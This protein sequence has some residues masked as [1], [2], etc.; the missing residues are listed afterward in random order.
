MKTTETAQSNHTTMRGAAAIAHILQ[1]EGVDL[2]TCFPHNEMID[3]VAD[4]GTQPIMCRTERIAIHIAD[5]YSRLS[6]GKKTPVVFVQDGPGIENAFGGVAQA[7]GD[8]TPMLLM[9]GGYDRDRQ[10]IGPNFQATYNFR[11]ITKWVAEVN[12]SARI[13]Q[14]MHYAFSQLRNGPQ[15]PVMLEVPTDVMEEPIANETVAGYQSPPSTQAS[16]DPQDVDEVVEALLAAKHPVIVAG[17]GIFYA[18]ACPAL[19]QFAELTQIPVMTT[20]NGK[21]AFPENH[22]LALGTGGASRTKMV[23]HFLD[24][25]DFVLGIGTSF[26][27]SPYIT[28]IPDGKIIAQIT[29]NSQD[30]GKDYVISYGVLGDAKLVLEQM[31]AKAQETLGKTG[32]QGKTAIANEVATVKAEF[33]AEWL[34]RLTNDDNP[35]SPY[36]VIWEVMQTFDR[37]RTT[38]TH[39]AGSP[40]DQVTATY[41]AIVPHGYIGWGKTTHLGTSL[42]LAMGA[43]LA[44]PDWYAVNIM[45]DG[46]FGMVGIDFET[47]VRYQIPICT[48]ILNNGVLG[49]YDGYLPISTEKF[50]TRN[51]T[52]DYAGVAQ[53]LGGY[54]ERVEQ[55]ADLKLALQRAIREMDAGRPVLLDVITREESI[56]AKY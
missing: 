8:N 50:G 55:V 30:I 31:I 44:K 33:M 29:H 14:M 15:G 16:G 35:I 4:L 17:Q 52:G 38:V 51:L 48:I 40:R 11:N 21:S 7:Y 49:G 3:T 53:S 2:V 25:A 36:R 6:D 24:K 42:G 32:R 47:A 23:R 46:A 41:E 9:P 37:T 12:Q 54:T 1:K 34:P 28:P 5:G 39:E 22:P 18:E 13:P 19:L 56:F 45:G 43:K 27:R 10:D 20:L 26:T